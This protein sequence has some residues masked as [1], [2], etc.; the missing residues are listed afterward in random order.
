[1]CGWVG[2]QI[3]PTRIVNISLLFLFSM[4]KSELNILKIK[5]CRKILR[6]MFRGRVSGS[7]PFN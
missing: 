5:K 1:M 3:I 7:V 4:I 2:G 6:G